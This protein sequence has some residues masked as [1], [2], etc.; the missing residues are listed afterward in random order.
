MR[1][2]QV[3]RVPAIEETVAWADLE[4]ESVLLNVLE[5]LYFGLDEVGTMIWKLVSE[6]LAADQIVARL[7]EEFEVAPEQ[8]EGD[9]ADFLLTLEAKK[10]IHF[11][12]QH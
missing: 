5:G 8:L 6:G 12:E 10:L 1:L 9:V 3:S 11:V 4:G 7:L 2:R